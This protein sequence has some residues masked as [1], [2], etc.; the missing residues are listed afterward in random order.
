MLRIVIPL[1]ELHGAPHAPLPATLGD[2]SDVGQSPFWRSEEARLDCVS[3][4]S[5]GHSRARHGQGGLG[6]GVALVVAVCLLVGAFAL[7]LAG[8]DDPS[9]EQRETQSGLLAR[10]WSIDRSEL[11]PAQQRVMAA[12]DVEIRPIEPPILDAIAAAEFRLTGSE[13][14]WFPRLVSAALWVVGGLFF[15]L[16]ARRL[17]TE[18][19]RSSRSRCTSSGRTRCGTAGS[20]CR[21]RFSCARSSPPP[22]PCFATG[23]HHRGDGSPSRRRRP[24]FATLVKPGI[25]FLFLVALHVAGDRA[26]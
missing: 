19:A 16:V 12:V 7:R 10:K 14:F 9:I 21:T 20:S 26:R 18:R 5:P 23:R 15:L 24:S 3:G 4:G 1:P 11:T 17:T 13:S 2:S 25:A 6:S 8:I 22:G